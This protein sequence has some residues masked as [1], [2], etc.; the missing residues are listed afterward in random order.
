MTNIAIN[1]FFGK[2]GQAIFQESQSLESCI[3]TVGVDKEELIKTK[4]LKNILLTSDIS[5]YADNFD[6]IIDFSLPDSSL[7][8]TEI[9]VTLNKP[10]VIGTT[11]FAETDLNLIMNCS[12]K[13]PIL[14]APN[15]S[16]GVNASFNAISILS[17]LLPN[18][19]VH[20]DETHHKNKVD[21]PS[22]TALKF[23]DMV[24]VA[25]GE[26][27]GDITSKHCPITFKSHRKD[28]EIGV[29][30]ITFKGSAD[31][32]TFTHTAENRDIFANGALK[33][34]EW[35]IQQPPGFYNYKNYMDS[36]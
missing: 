31:E 35:L 23:A 28:S 15:M 29:H 30:T 8:V 19:K 2:M 36:I 22:G 11:G 7:K 16:I 3:V 12:K 10:L 1:G 6:V 21:S 33:T 25:R 18:H 34:A 13:I 24:C 32:I 4:T 9:C 20:I 27:L 26:Q 17:K 14:L 5:K